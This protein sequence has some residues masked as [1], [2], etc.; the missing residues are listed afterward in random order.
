LFQVD[1]V[2]RHTRTPLVLFWLV[3]RE[4]GRGN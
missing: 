1:S 2:G 4:G 3:V